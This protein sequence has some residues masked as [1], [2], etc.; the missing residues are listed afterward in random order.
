MLEATLF[1]HW[2][3]VASIELTE[4]G[5]YSISLVGAS[6]GLLTKPEDLKDTLRV[7]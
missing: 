4:T 5:S 7:T 6:F 3:K 2:Y 1:G